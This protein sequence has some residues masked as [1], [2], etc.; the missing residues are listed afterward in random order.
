MTY[1]ESLKDA[2]GIGDVFMERRNKYM[3]ALV[4]AQEFLREP[5]F[6]NPKDRELIAAYTSKL[7][8]C[9][10]CCSSHVAFAVSVGCTEEEITLVVTNENVSEH[11]LGPILAYV[12]KLTL[13]PS[14]INQ[15]D[16]DNVLNNGFTENELKDAIA[17]CS[18][19]NFYNRI[20]E[21]H[22]IKRG[23]SEEDLS[24]ADRINEIGYDGRYS[25]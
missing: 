9:E 25:S 15:N 22:G 8:G 23:T 7:N 24:S 6:L 21:G 10:Y 1:F 12:K 11:R 4:L 18:L 17:I 3:P 20:V 2:K 16:I 5:S 14:S 19:F 13:S